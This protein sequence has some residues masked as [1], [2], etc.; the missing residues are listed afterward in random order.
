MNTV[1]SKRSVTYKDNKVT[2]TVFYFTTHI[3]LSLLFTQKSSGIYIIGRLVKTGL[4]VFVS[5]YL[6][7][8]LIDLVRTRDRVRGAEGFSPT[9]FLEINP[10]KSGESK[11]IGRQ[12][13]VRTEEIDLLD[14]TF[15]HKVNFKTDSSFLSTKVVECT[16]TST[17]GPYLKT[18]E[19]SANFLIT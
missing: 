19:N 15:C 7:T 18:L 13:C 16:E 12:S 11:E 3:L 10:R 1:T 8:S 4:T 2:L 9:N 5:L 17:W 14:L 6:L